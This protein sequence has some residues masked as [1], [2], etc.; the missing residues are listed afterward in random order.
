MLK[1]SEAIGLLES[2]NELTLN[3]YKC[4]NESAKNNFAEVIEYYSNRKPILENLQ[5]FFLSDGI[6][7]FTQRQ[8]EI[9]N[10]SIRTLIENDKTN[11]DLIE[12]KVN[13][14]KSSVQQIQKQKSLLIYSKS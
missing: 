2:A 8:R 11:I 5:S 14:L 6:Q 12:M 7:S 13:A 9:I 4:L 10:D 3:I 1:Y